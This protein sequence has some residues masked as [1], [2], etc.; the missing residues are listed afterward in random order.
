MPDYRRPLAHDFDV[1]FTFALA[2]RGSRA[3]FDHI[4]LLR[5]AAA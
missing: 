4:D 3:L 5:K 2:N 1:F